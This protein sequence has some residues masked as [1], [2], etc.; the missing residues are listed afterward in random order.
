MLHARLLQFCT[1]EAPVGLE[2]LLVHDTKLRLTY[3]LSRFFPSDFFFF[4][5]SPLEIF[6]CWESKSILDLL[7]SVLLLLAAW[8]VEPSELLR[9]A[10]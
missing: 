3:H 6:P 5:D 2:D 8:P 7:D 10:S 4:F 1:F 9:K